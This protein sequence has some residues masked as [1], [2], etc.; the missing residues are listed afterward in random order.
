MARRK[1]ATGLSEVIIPAGE[2]ARVLGWTQTRTKRWLMSHR[3]S[4]KEA[5][6]P[7][8]RVYT[9]RALIRQAFPEDADYILARLDE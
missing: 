5:T 7:Y 6:G 9:T 2:V 3:I 8:G 1:V 4:R